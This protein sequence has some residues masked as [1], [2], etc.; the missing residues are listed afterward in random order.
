MLV[1]IFGAG[2]S[3]DSANGNRYAST[4][5]HEW[6]P[7]LANELFSPRRN[8]FGPVMRRFRQGGALFMR[9][10]AA[11]EQGKPVEAAMQEAAD[12]IGPTD[13]GQRQMA[14]LRFYLQEVLWRASAEWSAGAFSQTNYLHL[15]DAI[16]QWRRR[17][18]DAVAY[19]T[20]NYDTMLEEGLKPILD[21]GYSADFDNYTSS[22]TRAY[23]VHGSVDWGHAVVRNTGGVQGDC[24]DLLIQDAPKLVASGRG[25]HRVIAYDFS[26]V[27]HGMTSIHTL[28]YPA[29]A[30]PTTGKAGFECPPDQLERL[31][32]DLA[33]MDRLLVIGWRGQEG[34]LLK[35]LAKQRQGVAGQVVCGD[36]AAAVDLAKRLTARMPNLT[37]APMPGGFSQYVA[38]GQFR[39]LLAQQPKTPARRMAA[40]PRDRRR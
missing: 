1:V 39:T 28:L 32:Q 14:A 34:H 11:I 6:R 18:D 19:V 26:Q 21:L 2:A 5:V 25:W 24:R 36:Q 10:Q 40:C 27:G 31:Q 9:L 12:E 33:N 13:L 20:F 29:L 7:P 8:S 3:F 4:L 16:E 15:A 23:K 22:R 35:L 30:L 17:N 37:A 38:E